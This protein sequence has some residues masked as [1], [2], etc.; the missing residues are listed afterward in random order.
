MPKDLKDIL[1]VSSLPTER[2]IPG[3]IEVDGREFWYVEDDGKGNFNKLFPKLLSAISPPLHKSGGAITGGCSLTL[4][5]GRVFHSF[6]Y[7]GDLAGWKAQVIQGAE[8]LG[9]GLGRI[10]GDK[11]E[12][13]EG[14]A[15]L[16]SDCEVN[17]Y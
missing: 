5:D 14:G 4:P 3:T 13:Q 16:L 8:K 15:F 10:K 12:L 11:I 2:E 6:S 17:F 7:K 9:L 1:G